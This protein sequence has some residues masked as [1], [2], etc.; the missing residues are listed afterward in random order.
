MSW[1]QKKK[2]C[3]QSFKPV[4]HHYTKK[5]K[6]ALQQD[7]GDTRNKCL[8]ICSLKTFFFFKGEIVVIKLI[9]K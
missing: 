7:I 9:W 6:W 1:S 4:L 8:Y 2:T 3:S 5:I